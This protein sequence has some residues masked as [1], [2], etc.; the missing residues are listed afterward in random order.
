MANLDQQN[1][2]Q[3]IKRIKD[4]RNNSYYDQELRMHV[5]KK[6]TMERVRKIREQPSFLSAFLVSMILGAFALMIAQAIRFRYFGVAEFGRVSVVIDLVVA[7]WVVGII[8]A[9]MDR[10]KTSARIAQV[11]GICVMF[12]SGHNLI[13]RWPAE[14]G[15]LYTNEYVLLEQER[16]RAG[17]INFPR[18]IFLSK[19]EVAEE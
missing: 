12:V 5:P 16:T 8:A 4:P 15:I 6:V 17:T 19:P 11:L 9:L 3:R 10:K 14:M 13:W 2:Q 7:L 18:Q 1:F